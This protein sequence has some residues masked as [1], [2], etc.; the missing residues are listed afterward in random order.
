MGV[1]GNKISEKPSY[2]K[3]FGLSKAC[4]HPKFNGN[5]YLYPFQT[6]FFTS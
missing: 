5:S 2:L 6:S 1:K 4:S 3:G